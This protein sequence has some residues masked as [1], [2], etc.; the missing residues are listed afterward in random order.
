MITRRSVLSS[1]AVGAASLVAGAGLM[2]SN[3]SAKRSH[4][5]KHRHKL[6][7][8]RARQRRR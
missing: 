1:L 8:R 4:P 6:N 5:H 2:A 3:V 7:H